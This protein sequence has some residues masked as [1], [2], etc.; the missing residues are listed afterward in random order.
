MIKTAGHSAGVDNFRPNTFI[1]T[2]RNWN[3]PFFNDQVFDVL[4]I[5]AIEVYHFCKAQGYFAI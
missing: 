2:D 1:Y 5:N 3:G 4:V